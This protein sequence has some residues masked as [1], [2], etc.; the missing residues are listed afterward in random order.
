MREE[1]ILTVAWE[2]EKHREAGKVDQ[3]ASRL[4]DK[5]QSSKQSQLQ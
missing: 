4:S 5:S 1:T 3:I 2:R